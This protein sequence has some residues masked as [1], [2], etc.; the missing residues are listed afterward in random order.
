M[1]CPVCGK[2]A[3]FNITKNP[4]FHQRKKLAVL[5]ILFTALLFIPAV[6]IEAVAFS[7][8]ILALKIAGFVL[9]AAL[10]AMLIPV[11]GLMKKRGKNG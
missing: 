2:A 5:N 7:R 8:G 9:F 1:G 3:M 10:V 6:L 4:P 11:F